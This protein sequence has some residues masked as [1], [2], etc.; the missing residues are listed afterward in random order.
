MEAVLSHIA[1]DSLPAAIGR[2][3]II[4][5]LGSGAMGRVYLAEDPLLDRKIALKVISVDPRLQ[6]ETH[7]EY[8]TRFTIE[9]KASAKLTHPS[10]VQVFDAGEEDGEPWIAFQLIKGESLETM[11]RRRGRLTVRRAMLFAIDMASAL[12]HAHSWNIIHRDIKPANIIIEQSSG[13]AKL[14]D[15]GIAQAPWSPPVNDDYIV[16]SPG[17][18]SPEQIDGRDVDQRSDLFAL[19]IVMYLMLTGEHPF[20][21]KTLRTTCDATRRGEYTPLR[22]I[23]PAIPRAI[24]MAVHRCLYPDLRMRM[25]TAAELVD[26]LRPALPAE[27]SVTNR[28][29]VEPRNIIDGRT[30]AMDQSGS[31]VIGGLFFQLQAMRR[32]TAM[33]K[34][35]HAAIAKIAGRRECFAG[36]TMEELG[37]SL[38]QIGRKTRIMLRLREF[39]RLVS[40]VRG[41]TGS[42]RIIVWGCIG[43]SALLL[44]MATIMFFMR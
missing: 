17:F 20:L 6:F 40:E 39:T 25:R 11:L 1:A 28:A 36:E 37:E 26:I 33:L 38:A 9:A 27:R 8:L 13:I 35:L 23:I 14:A 24:D 12:Q 31:T 15:F 2:Y 30:P 5:A 22:Q 4:K 42:T 3:R 34:V 29:P 41:L 7:H 43:S 21:R 44:I 32:Y 16:G 10:I 18:M 19:G